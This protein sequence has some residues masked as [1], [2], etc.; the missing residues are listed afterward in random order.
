MNS[1]RIFVGV[2]A[3]ESSHRC[4]RRTQLDWLRLPSLNLFI[5][6]S[7]SNWPRER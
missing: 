7:S 3:F 5:L 1:I 2:L 6:L 4:R